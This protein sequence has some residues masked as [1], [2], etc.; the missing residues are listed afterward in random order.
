MLISQPQPQQQPSFPN[1]H[2]WAPRTNLTYTGTSSPHTSF[3]SRTPKSQSSRRN[4]PPRNLNPLRNTTALLPLHIDNIRVAPT[5]AADAVLLLAVPFRPV[6]VVLLQ[7]FEV[8]P[9]GGG[10]FLLEIGSEVRFAGEL[11]GGRVGGAVLD[12]G[13]AVAEV[14]EVVDV[15][16]REEGAGCEGV[17]WGVAPL[18]VCQ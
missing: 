8:L 14:A 18:G 9:V 17:D 2:L 13:V 3:P 12:G 5:P 6:V 1:T 16:G 15:G 10:A 11:A 7:H 4:K